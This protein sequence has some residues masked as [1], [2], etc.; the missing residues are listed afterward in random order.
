MSKPN[1]TSNEVYFNLTYFALKLLGKSLYSNA[2]TAISEL[3]ANGIDANAKNVKLLLDMRNKKH[4]TIEVYDDGDG[5]SYTDIVE[6]YV[7]VG[8]D[9]RLEEGLTEKRKEELLGRKG[10]GKLAALYLSSNY[11][12]C[13]KNNA[14]D[15]EVWNF[16]YDPSKESNYPVLRKYHEIK[17]EP[18]CYS[19]LSNRKSGTIIYLTDVD[20]TNIGGRTIEGLKQRI[21]DYYLYDSLECNIQVCILNDENDELKFDGIKKYIAFKNIYALFD[22]T[23]YDIKNKISNSVYVRSM[24]EE[25]QKKK[26]KTIILDKL[27]ECKGKK[28]FLKKST[29]EK[30]E[31]NY[32]LEGWIGIHSSIDSSVAQKNDIGFLKNK[33]YNPFKLR[34][35]VRKKLAVD[36]FLTYLG[37]TQAFIN[38]IEGEIS[39]DIL[40]SN[41]LDDIATSSREGYPK[42]DERIQ[43]L[44]GIVKNIVYRLIAERVAIG[45][46]VTQEEIEL[47]EEAE[48]KRKEEEN[49]K[50]AAILKYEIEKQK[51]E[52]LHRQNVN[53]FNNITDDQS[54]FLSKTHLIKT[55]MLS[56]KKS[57]Q[58]LLLKV[59]LKEYKE[60]RNISLCIDKVLSLVKYGARANFNME[61]EIIKGDLA[62]FI[63]QY[64]DAVLSIQYSHLQIMVD[65]KAEATESKFNPQYIALIFDNLLSNSKKS[66][67]KRVEICIRRESNIYIIDYNDNGTGIR[68]T[69]FND[70][71]EL[72]VSYTNGTGIGM[73]NVKNAVKEMGGN[74]QVDTEYEKGARFIFTLGG[75]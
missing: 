5:M 25:I 41:E 49:K 72:G 63:Q 46:K 75:N 59:D 51:N 57:F 23:K 31:L 18:F 27:S 58:S 55:N 24:Y 73:Y 64:C 34:L 33:S 19:E 22:N 69:S 6:K 45:N 48:R 47:K 37:L 38:Y 42:D 7:V 65:N 2:W 9:K 32:S 20:L 15:V 11:Y 62:V 4:A 54:D 36:N 67:S 10:I 61:S 56:L 30:R 14:G 8:K 44:I 53:L 29:G 12:I 71:F 28:V 68:K 50:N 39:F 60:I 74:I 13:T 21:S 66:K 3:V 17:K 52:V 26:R 40:D 16:K 43:L 35:Y 70:L 1:N